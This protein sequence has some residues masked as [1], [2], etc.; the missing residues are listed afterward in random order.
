MNMLSPKKTKFR[1]QFKGRIH[2]NA[3]R[4]T[5]ANTFAGLDVTD[6]NAK[7]TVTSISCT[8]ES[9]FKDVYGDDM[10]AENNKNIF[11]QVR[12]NNDIPKKINHDHIIL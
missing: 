5:F 2:G 12:F 8:P 9:V 6:L 3:T 11:F 4:A 10:V 1:K 7:V